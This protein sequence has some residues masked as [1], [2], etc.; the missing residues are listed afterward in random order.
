[1]AEA[2]GDQRLAE[3]LRRR[4]LD[5]LIPTLRE[6]GCSEPQDLTHLYASDIEQ[7]G[8]KLAKA[9]KLWRDIRRLADGSS[10]NADAAGVEHQQ[11]AADSSSRVE[12]SAGTCRMQRL[13]SCLAASSMSS[14]VWLSLPPH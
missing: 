2:H 4:Q 5:H 8:L 9:R 11:Q 10:Q 12:V 6:W 7:L 3:W 1:M 13:H 14:L